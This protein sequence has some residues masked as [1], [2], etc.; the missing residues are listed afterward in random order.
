MNKEFQDLKDHFYTRKKIMNNTDTK[1][2]RNSEHL[3]PFVVLTNLHLIYQ[4][5]CIQHNGTE[6]YCTV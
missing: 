2:H 3:A 4:A 1:K 6:G 5:L